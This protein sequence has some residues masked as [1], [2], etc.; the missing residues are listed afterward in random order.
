M[1]RH[2]ALIPL[3]HDHHHTLVLALRLK[4]GRAT[5]HKDLWPKDLREQLARTI[6]F[7]N[8]EILPHF[9]KEE[10]FVFP[11]ARSIPEV[12]PLIEELKRQHSDIRSKFSALEGLSSD[13]EILAAFSALGAALEFHIRKEEREL[14]PMLEEKLS[15]EAFGRIEQGMS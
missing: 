14:F 4:K 7:V 8:E 15:E 10:Q 1:P 9:A 13:E 3:S 11:E 6:E 2:A 5:T 12:G